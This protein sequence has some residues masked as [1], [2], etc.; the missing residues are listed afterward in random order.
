MKKLFI[1]LFII[2]CLFVSCKKPTDNNDEEKSIPRSEW[3]SDDIYLTNTTKIDVYDFKRQY[4]TNGIIGTFIDERRANGSI[5]EKTTYTFKE[6]GYYEY[7]SWKYAGSQYLEKKD[8]GTYKIKKSEING[9]FIIRKISEQGHGNENFFYQVT[10]NY[11]NFQ[12]Y[13]IVD[14]YAVNPT[15]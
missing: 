11:L 3:D 13:I 15:W 1:G 8:S 12:P 2:S 14:G 9:Y 6:T 10:R 5:I 7:K 4:G